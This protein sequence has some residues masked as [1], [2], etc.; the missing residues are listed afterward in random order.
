[1]IH[2][3]KYKCIENTFFNFRFGMK[4]IKLNSIS[5]PLLEGGFL[6]PTVI[7]YGTL[8]CSCFNGEET[9]I[10]LLIC[11]NETIV[12]CNVISFKKI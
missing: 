4:F 8:I 10:F 9:D 6:I 12:K 3:Q 11:N 2:V 7:F 5:F 1:M